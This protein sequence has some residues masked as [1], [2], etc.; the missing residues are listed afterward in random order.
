MKNI[1]SKNQIVRDKVPD[2]IAQQKRKCTYRI[3]EDSDYLVALR[4]KILEEAKEFKKSGEIEEL[5]DILGIMHCYLATQGLS[6]ASLEKIRLDKK[7]IRGSFERKIFLEAY[8][9]SHR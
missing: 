7:E 5:A 9:S 2:I 1:K 3:L 8:E 4:N 6:F